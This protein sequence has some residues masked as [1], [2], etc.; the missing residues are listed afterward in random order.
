MQWRRT[1][2]EIIARSFLPVSEW[3][4]SWEISLSA[5]NGFSKTT[6]GGGIVSLA[7]GLR[8]LLGL[9]PVVKFKHTFQRTARK[10]PDVTFFHELQ[11]IID[12][13][14]QSELYSVM[15]FHSQ[16]AQLAFSFFCYLC[17]LLL[18]FSEFLCRHR[19]WEGGQGPWLLCVSYMSHFKELSP[20]GFTNIVRRVKQQI[21]T[22][23]QMSPPENCKNQ[24]TEGRHIG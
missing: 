7:S 20:G 3:S 8:S 6:G 1:E 15:S 13:P 12:S 11:A 16:T 19:K 4:V 10:C 18:A 5:S 14:F 24:Q 21:C 9:A 17:L 23:P 22:I 2:A